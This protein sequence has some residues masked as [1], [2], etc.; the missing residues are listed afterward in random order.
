MVENQE[1]HPL[2]GKSASGRLS[3]VRR[4]SMLGTRLALFWAGRRVGQ[5]GSG[6]R[7]YQLRAGAGKTRRW[8][9]YE[10]DQ[11]PETVPPAWWLWLHHVTEDPA[12][13]KTEDFTQPLPCGTKTSFFKTRRYE[14]WGPQDPV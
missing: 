6:N 8:V 5:D 13:L 10:G 2:S 12:P 4:L 14:A 3:F 1:S 9:L 7:Y 11:G